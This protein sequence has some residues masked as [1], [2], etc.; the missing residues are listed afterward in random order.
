MLDNDYKEFA[1]LTPLKALQVTV[2]HE[3]NHILQFGIDYNEQVWMFEA[4]ATWMEEQVYPAVSDWLRYVPAFAASTAEPLTRA[5]AGQGLKIYGDA[6]FLH[7]LSRGSHLGPDVVRDAWLRSPKVKPKHFASTAINSSIRKNGG[8]GF[9]PLFSK[10]A[11]ATA[12]W[13]AGKQ[14][15]D[16]KRLKQ[17]KRAGD[18]AAGTGTQLEARP[19]RLRAL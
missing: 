7:F 1:P 3:Y 9:A 2:A 5:S 16:A 4:S 6:S 8:T 11:A 15:P 18:L 13:N 14:F 17:V 10:F 19:S 12:E